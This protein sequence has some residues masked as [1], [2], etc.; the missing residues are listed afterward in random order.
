MFHNGPFDN[1]SIQF[2]SI[3]F[4]SGKAHSN[5]KKETQKHKKVETQKTHR[6]T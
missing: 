6:H 5:N 1:F 4:V 3:Y 2:H